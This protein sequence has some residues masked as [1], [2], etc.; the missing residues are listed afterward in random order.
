MAGLLIL[1]G[2]GLSGYAA[3]QPSAAAGLRECV[4]YPNPALRSQNPVVRAFIGVV[5]SVEV[6]ILDI[7]GQLV[8][9][10]QLSGAPTGLLN[11]ESYYDYTWSG[12][13]SSGVYF[14]IVHGKTAAGTMVRA[15]ARF[16]VVK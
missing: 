16:A 11:G 9:S 6:T 3:I 2:L 13:K 14:A 4:V 8:H 1:S 12:P 10:G 15:R 5:D 7:S